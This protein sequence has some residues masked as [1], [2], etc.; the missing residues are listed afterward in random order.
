MS[1][2]RKAC[3]GMEKRDFQKESKKG[4]LLT[5]CSKNLELIIQLC[6]DSLLALSFKESA[7]FVRR[8]CRFHFVI[9]MLCFFG[10]EKTSISPPAR[11]AKMGGKRNAFFVLLKLKNRKGTSIFQRTS[12]LFMPCSHF[13]QKKT[14]IFAP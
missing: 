14:F 1:D 3:V 4:L 6:Q 11:S 13:F 5:F 10:G 12:S 9:L 2:W 7:A 8:K